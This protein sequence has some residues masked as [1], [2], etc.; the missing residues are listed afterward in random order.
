VLRT[1][2]KL[3]AIC[4]A[5]AII[6]GL[7][8]AV[9]QPA[10]RQRKVLELQQALA[11]LTPAGARV[12]EGVA[13]SDQPVVRA[14]Y[15]VSVPGRPGGAIL[16]LKADGYGGE[17]K[18]LARYGNDGEIQDALLMDNAETPGLGKKAETAAYMRKF[19]GTGGAGRPVPVRKEM[20]PAR[21][22]DAVTGATITFIAVARALQDGSR[23]V[24]ERP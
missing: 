9:T 10:I 23:F 19:L 11:R 1:G 7:V 22:A 3:F 8:N 2:G 12:G 6:L 15:P 17:M 16:E 24:R 21:E 4:T 13:V 20:L 18:L 5:A 14:Y